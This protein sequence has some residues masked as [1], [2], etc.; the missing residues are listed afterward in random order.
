MKTHASKTSAILMLALLA[1]GCASTKITSFLAPGFRHPVTI[2][3]VSV[4]HPDMD[5]RTMAENEFVK[6]LFPEVRAIP[7][8]G[9]MFPG[10]SY[11]GSEIKQIVAKTG[12]TAVLRISAKS[13]DSGVT[14]GEP[15]TTTR[16]TPTSGGGFKA[17]STTSPGIAVSWATAQYEARLYDA[18]TSEV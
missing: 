5:I 3:V 16:V 18:A 13:A 10:R 1:A 4:E 7:W 15:T 11:E 8:T 6:L 17:T 12:A 9:L 14:F 2:V